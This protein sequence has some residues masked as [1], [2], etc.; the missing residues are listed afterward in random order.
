[1]DSNQDQLIRRIRIARERAGLT[2]AQL[3]ERLGFNDRQ[4]LSAI[5]AGQR[6]ITAEELLQFMQVLGVDL[7]FLTDPFLLI[8]EPR[9]SWRAKDAPATLDAFE[10]KVRPLVGLYRRLGTDLG[11]TSPTLIPQLPLDTNSRYE[12]AAIAAE[13]LA[14]E[15]K[16]GDVPATRL[17]PAAE[18]KLNLLVL[19]ID[20]P[21]E[22]SG[23]ALAL[24]DLPVILVNRKEPEGRRNY[25]FAH[26]LFHILTWRAMP[27]PERDVINP[28]GYKA[29]RVEQLA[30]SFGAALLMPEQTM[31]RLAA[32]RPADSELHDWVRTTSTALSVSGQA[33]YY[34][35]KNLGL[36]KDGDGW[37]E[38]D[39]LVRADEGAKPK[40]YSRRFL[41][42]LHAGIA[43]G[44][45]S[46]RRTVRLMDFTVEDLADLFRDYGLEPP[47]GL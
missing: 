2:Q 34:R 41:E 20:A 24:N 42:R 28:S 47:F 44:H 3:S 38:P 19:M 40:L 10:E 13:K 17:L 29:K 23:A 5:E 36:L 46:V 45:V 18:E 8:G 37:M 12:D 16:L 14:A 4:T 22:V 9:F 26:E 21:A 33:F 1:M 32:E 27:P 30:E 43:G 6:K 15:W 11:A 7:D 31:Q 39:R 35:L 25:D